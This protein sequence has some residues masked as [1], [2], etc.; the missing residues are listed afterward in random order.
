[1]NSKEVKDI[2]RSLGADLCGI[3]SI[4]MFR[5]APKGYHPLNVMPTCKCVESRRN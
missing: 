5:D 4:D 3:A 1:M 2:L